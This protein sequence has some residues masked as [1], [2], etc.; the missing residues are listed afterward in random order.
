M[1]KSKLKAT[2]M[3]G[4]RA[5]VAILKLVD[6]PNVIQ[7]K[8]VH[9]T[10]RFL[11]VVMVLVKGGDLSKVCLNGKVSEYV[12]QCF[13]SQILSALQYIHERGIVHRDLKPA[14][15]LMSQSDNLETANL[16]LTDF[17]LSR[18]AMP[19]ERM[20]DCVWY[21]IPSFAP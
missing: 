9:E 12:A 5:E 18:F 17:G 14:N 11:Y 7:L 20:K 16:Y 19:F 21:T 8:S 2:D 10:E 4:L 6:H 1:D 13:I 15:I 3:E